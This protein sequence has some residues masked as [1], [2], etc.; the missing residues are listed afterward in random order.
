MLKLTYIL[1]LGAAV[2][3][4]ACG[5]SSSSGNASNT[6][7]D[8]STG[9]KTSMTLGVSDAAVTNVKAVNIVIDGITLKK[10]SV[11]SVFDTKDENGNPTQINLLQYTGDAMFP[12][13]S[14]VELD[15]GDYEWLRANIINGTS[16]EN[17]ELGS[18]I[19]YSDDTRAPLDVKRKGNDGVGEI[20]INEVTINEGENS[21][22]LEFDLNRSLVTPKNDV[23][24]YL[25]PTSI[26]LENVSQTYTLSGVIS[27]ELSDACVADNIDLAPTEGEYKHVVYLYDEE[28][29][30]PSDISETDP[31]NGNSPIATETVDEQNKYAIGFVQAGTYK[32]GYSCIGH[33]DDAETQEE[34][35][36]LYQIKP[37]A[38]SENT[39]LDFSV[40]P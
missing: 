2:L 18:H 33:I 34:A 16:V 6:S 38:I 7:Q 36:K 12:L 23:T 26:R 21:L 20:Q 15:A 29:M 30:E 10:E 39:T 5:G 4:S 22:V 32:V 9:Q 11:T 31:V 24:V 19:V 3:L 14:D 17:V 1:P 37:V 8:I 25:K 13:L 35:F 40:E 28:A 27:T